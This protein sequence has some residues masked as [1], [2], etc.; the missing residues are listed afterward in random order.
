MDRRK[1]AIILAAVLAAVLVAVLTGTGLVPSRPA[2]ER[3]TNL[4]GTGQQ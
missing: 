4:P 2:V 3:P 1:L